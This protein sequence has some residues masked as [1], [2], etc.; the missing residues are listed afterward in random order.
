MIDEK[1]VQEISKLA[2]QA[3]DVRIVRLEDENG[4]LATDER[5]FATKQLHVITPPKPEPLAIGT[6]SGVVDWFKSDEGEESEAKIH[7]ASARRVVVIST[8]DPV[9]RQ[10]EEHVVAEAQQCGFP[11]DKLM[12]LEQFII[13][14]QIH[15]EDS[16][17]KAALL[18]GV[19]GI[20][21]NE[22]RTAIDDGISQQ[23]VVKNC[24]GRLETKELAPI[25][26]L[27]PFRTFREV[28]QPI[29]EFLLRMSK[30]PGDLPVVALYSA[31]GAAW[32]VVAVQSI[33]N[34][35]AEKLPNVT[36]IR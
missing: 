36:V 17:E 27:R 25:Q 28:E 20:E 8:P 30:G 22:V 33:F 3:A 7:I 21:K 6:L 14:V 31:Q 26:L 16:A 5:F 10:R 35:F 12:D 32:Q 29:G 13:N 24:I 34:F 4:E 11:F 19:A 23:V 18:R 2:Q 15:F 1:F 9:Y